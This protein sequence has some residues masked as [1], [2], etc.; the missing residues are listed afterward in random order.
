MGLLL[1]RRALLLLLFTT[2]AIISYSFGLSRR[3]QCET[4]TFQ[5]TAGDAAAVVTA[6]PLPSII[7][8]RIVV[9]KVLIGTRPGPYELGLVVLKEYAAM[10]GYNFHVLRHG[11]SRMEGRAPAWAKLLLYEDLCATNQFDWVFIQDGDA[12]ILNK[13]VRLETLIKE[14]GADKDLI[15][16]ADTLILKSGVMFCRCSEWTQNGCSAWLGKCG[17][18]NR[19]TCRKM[20]PLQPPWLVAMRIAHSMSALHVI[21]RQILV[22]AIRSL[23]NATRML[24]APP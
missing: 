5:V 18:L 1:R 22:G 11:H 6:T 9:A 8:S 3:T 15:V 10:Y 23:Q 12:M 13:T 2:V 7:A 14:G 20:V 19:V 21:T 24:I 4:V 17:R 16:I